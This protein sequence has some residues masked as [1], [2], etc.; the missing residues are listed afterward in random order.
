MTE[1]LSNNSGETAQTSTEQLSDNPGETTQ[2][3]KNDGWSNFPPFQGDKPAETPTE[4]D[5][6]SLEAVENAPEDLADIDPDQDPDQVSEYDDQLDQEE[7][8]E[9]KERMKAWEKI[10]KMMKQIQDQLISELQK[11]YED[12]HD[13]APEERSDTLPSLVNGFEDKIEASLNEASSPDDFIQ[14]I[15]NKISPDGVKE[16]K[17]RIKAIATGA[18]E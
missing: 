1:Q 10:Q 2:T 16:V 9:Y 5:E 17:D 8:D 4:Q 13:K 12:N 18:G 15:I 7:H 14:T 11:Y 3:P 6:I